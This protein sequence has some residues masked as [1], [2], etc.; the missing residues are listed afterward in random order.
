MSPFE[1]ETVT[2]SQEGH[3][4]TYVF[5]AGRH[6]WFLDILRQRPH[7]NPAWFHLHRR[8]LTENRLLCYADFGANIG[9]TSLLPAKIGHQVLA[10]EAGPENLMCLQEAARRSGVTG[11]LR[12]AHW[13]AGEALGLLTFYEVSA[14]GSASV[15]PEH[16]DEAR[17]S[18]VPMATAAQILAFHDMTDV[19]VLKMDIEGAELAAL[20]GF[21]EIVAGNDSLE[22][23]IESNWESSRHHGYPPQ[24]IWQRLRELGFDTYILDGRRLTPVTPDMPQP[25]LVSEVLATRRPQAA[26]AHPLGYDLVPMD[27]AAMPQRLEQA[28]NKGRPDEVNAGFLAEQLERLPK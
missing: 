23:I 12:A 9:V 20:N 10:V 17:A 26:L 5:A 27:M 7:A 15:I 28:L 13:A 3:D 25:R 8:R 4:I 2:H 14:W 1:I 11:T 24:A 6:D 18:I 19:D 22:L 16:V 21:E